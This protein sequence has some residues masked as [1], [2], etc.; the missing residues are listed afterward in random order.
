VSLQV[1]YEEQ[2]IDQAAGF[3]A[4]DPAGVQQLMDAVDRLADE[5]RP[6]LSF[7][8]GSPDL[9]RLRVGRYRVMYEIRDD[10]ILVG[11]IARALPGR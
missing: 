8:Y 4:H 5:P 10:S 1:V 6:A 2:A 11:N 7:P 9:R 3:L